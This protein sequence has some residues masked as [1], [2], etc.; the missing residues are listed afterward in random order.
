[1]IHGMDRLPSCRSSDSSVEVDIR[2]PS[3]PTVTGNVQLCHSYCV[4]ISRVREAVLGICSLIATIV[5]F[6]HAI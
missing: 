4:D 5:E 6:S 1:M 3:V 2:A